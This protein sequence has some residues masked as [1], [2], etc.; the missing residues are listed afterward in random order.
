[1]SCEGKTYEVDSINFVIMTYLVIGKTM[2]FLYFRSIRLDRDFTIRRNIQFVES[3]FV[4]LA[5]SLRC[6]RA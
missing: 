5:K 6:F 1:M 3:V 2:V 4:D